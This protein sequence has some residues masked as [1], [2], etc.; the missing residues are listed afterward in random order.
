MTVKVCDGNLG[1]PEGN[2]RSRGSYG[3]SKKKKKRGHK[4]AI[5][6]S[7]QFIVEA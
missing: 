5:R 4:R 7:E 2:P 3:T 1:D 6:K